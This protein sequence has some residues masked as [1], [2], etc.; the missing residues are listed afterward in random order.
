MKTFIIKAID[1]YDERALTWDCPETGGL[2]FHCPFKH[3]NTMLKLQIHL[4]LLDAPYPDADGVFPFVLG[5]AYPACKWQDKEVVLLGYKEWKKKLGRVANK[6][7][8]GG[9]GLVFDDYTNL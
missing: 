2:G 5:C 4:K 7:K 9:W 1:K 3:W 6:P 8:W